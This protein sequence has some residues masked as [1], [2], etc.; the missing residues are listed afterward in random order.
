MKIIKILY[1]FTNFIIIVNNVNMTF[2]DHVL[3]YKMVFFKK[4]LKLNLILAYLKEVI[5]IQIE[6]VGDAI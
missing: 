3:L 5:M 1:N 4:N 6:K 2:V